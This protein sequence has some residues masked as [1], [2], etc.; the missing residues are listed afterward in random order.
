MTPGPPEVFKPGGTPLV[1]YVSRARLRLEDQLRSGLEREHSFTVVSGPTKTG[2]TVLCR[3]VLGDRKIVEIDGG[4]VRTLDEFWTHV[5]Y[6]LNLPSSAS[7]SRTKGVIWTGVVEASASFLKLF[8]VKTSVSR[9]ESDQRNFTASYTNIPVIASIA[10]LLEEEQTILIEDFHYIEAEVQRAILRSLKNAVAR[11]LHVVLLAVPH[12]AFDPVTVEAELSGRVEHIELP[13]W[14]AED[15][16]EIAE[17]GFSEL[18]LAVPSNVQRKI[19]EDGF[20]NPL[21][22]QDLCLRISERIGAGDGSGFDGEDLAHIYDAVVGGMGTRRY[23]RLGQARA[24]AN[25]PTRVR[26]KAGH[27]EALPAAV[28]AAIARLGPKASNPLEEICAS[29]EVLVQDALTIEQIE[30]TL[31]QIGAVGAEGG[32]PSLEWLAG[33]Q[34]LVITDPYLLFYLKWQITDRRAMRLPGRAIDRLITGP[35]TDEPAPPAEDEK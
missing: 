28:L 17:R 20:G 19:C 29:L 10:R 22:V 21:V 16:A 7:K 8:G 13:S 14:S 3:R 9:A 5:A 27:E 12:R 24:G 4:Q 34:V 35:S 1:T 30:A 11:G 32:A 15:L 31:A 33:E 23:E 6:R 18:K 2:K 26:M 25:Y